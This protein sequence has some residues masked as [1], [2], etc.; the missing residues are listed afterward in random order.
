MELEY[1]Q[2][3]KIEAAED[4]NTAGAIAVLSLFAGFIC[5]AFYVMISSL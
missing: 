1:K 3:G 2:T 5:S 4:F